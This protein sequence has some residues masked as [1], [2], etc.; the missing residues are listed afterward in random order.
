MAP[1]DLQLLMGFYQAT[2]GTCPLP[3]EAQA[4]LKDAGVTPPQQ[5]ISEQFPIGLPG[6]EGLELHK[7]GTSQ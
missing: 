3:S 1:E 2:F 5:L 7:S 4:K 6:I